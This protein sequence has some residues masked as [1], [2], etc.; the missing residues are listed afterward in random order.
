MAT[1]SRRPRRRIEQRP[2]A[3]QRGV[4]G[5]GI[6]RHEHRI[7]DPSEPGER[8]RDLGGRVEAD[9]AGTHLVHDG[10]HAIRGRR[11]D[12]FRVRTQVARE[13]DRV[14]GAHGDDVVGGT[15]RRD[16]RRVAAGRDEVAGELLVL[17]DAGC[18]VENQHVDPFARGG[19]RSLDPLGGEFWPSTRSAQPGEHPEAG[20]AGAIPLGDPLELGDRECTAAG[21]TACGRE[22][23]CLIEQTRTP[24][25]STQRACR[26]RRARPRRP[27][28]RVPRRWRW[29]GSCGRAS[30]PGP[31]P[32]ARRRDAPTASAAREPDVGT[33]AAGGSTVSTRG[34]RDVARR[35][36]PAEFAQT[37]VGDP[38]RSA[39]IAPAR[40]DSPRRSSGRRHGRRSR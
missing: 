23:G 28:R 9:R 13:S 39:R 31:R 6:P 19:D 24:G 14:A 22:A 11:L 7:G 20:V 1:P 40:A 8:L 17:F 10:R 38:E 3:E 12:Q 15:Q 26:R 2:P 27:R 34:V 18:G 33:S 32:R 30:L 25:R 21:E 37:G 4:E 35:R 5:G 36:L 16:R 29:P